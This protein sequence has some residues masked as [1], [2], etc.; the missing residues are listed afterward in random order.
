M[1]LLSNI[2]KAIVKEGAESNQ[3]LHVLYEDV[4]CRIDE[5]EVKEEDL[6]GMMCVTMKKTSH[7][8]LA[9]I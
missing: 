5:D 8:Y 1:P 4:K 2:A 9:R 3:E 6:L 7:H